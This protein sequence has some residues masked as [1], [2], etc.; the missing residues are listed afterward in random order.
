M[1]GILYFYRLFVYHFEFGQMNQMI[2]ELLSLME[3]RL[4][5]LI[6]IPSMFVATITGGI[7]IFMNPALI[8]EKWF[9]IKLLSAVGMVLVTLFGFIVLKN[10][11]NFRFLKYS[12]I[13][14][15]FLNEIPTILMIIIVVMVVIR[16]FNR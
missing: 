4:L 15:R 6:T 11:I 3:K 12:S 1:A 13:K 16:P 8:K 10:F 14:L 9:Q 2:Q 7:M 5:K